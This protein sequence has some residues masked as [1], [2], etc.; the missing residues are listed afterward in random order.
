MLGAVSPRRRIDELRHA[1][2]DGA[3]LRYRAEAR[4]LRAIRFIL[5]SAA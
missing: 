1:G 3:A 4:G 2:G 5:F